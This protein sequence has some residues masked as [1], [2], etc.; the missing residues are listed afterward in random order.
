M[1]L[2]GCGTRLE[3]RVVTA[4]GARLEVVLAGAGDSTVVFESALGSD[5]ATAAKALPRVQREE[6]AA[7]EGLGR[8]S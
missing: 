1:L 8:A 7:F 6:L 5:S 2:T 4:N 3:P